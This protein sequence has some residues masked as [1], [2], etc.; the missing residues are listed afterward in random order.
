MLLLQEILDKELVISKDLIKKLISFIDLTTLNN[1]DTNSA[2]LKLVE[3][4]NAG[5]ENLHPAAVCTFSN[6]GELV[7]E[8]LNPGIQAAVVG[9]CFPTGQ[10]LTEAKI[11]EIKVISKT[12]VDEI[13]IVLNRGDFF[14]GKDQQIIDEISGIKKAMG[15]MDLKVILETG[16]LESEENIKK[17]AELAIEAGADFIKTSTGKT[18]TGATPL[19]TFVM[20]HVIKAHFE[21]NGKKIGLK[22]SGGIRTTTDALTYYSIVQQILGEEWLNP[23]L[24][25]IGA[26]SLYDN[27]INDYN[28]TND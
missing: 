26:S 8:N 14:D 3:K 23:Q 12:G 19:A 18:A 2:V 17:A 16:D 5:F 21:K 10:T 25:R 13:D 9:G 6:F 1:T 27:L 22:P 4:A 28:I 20:C 15:N 11:E 24:F 7:R